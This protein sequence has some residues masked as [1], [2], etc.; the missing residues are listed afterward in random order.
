M[1]AYRPIISEAP[2]VLG[3]HRRRPASRLL[4]TCAMCGWSRT[5]DPE[6]VIDRLRALRAGGHCSPVGPLAR[7]DA[8]P[9]PMCRRVKWRT[10]LAQPTDLP[11]RDARRLADRY[12]N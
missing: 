3:D 10:D 4:L 7:R 2:L 1:P 9:C 5:Y 11:A 12:R 6:R 8:W